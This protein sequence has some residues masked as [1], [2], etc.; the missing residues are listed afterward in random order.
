VT[1]GG[2]R[3]VGLGE[4]AHHVEDLFVEAQILRSASAGNDESVVL[5]DLDVGKGGIQNKVV[6]GLFGVG[7]ISSKS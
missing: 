1:D 5:I 2:D 3:L 7:L 4:I 6:P